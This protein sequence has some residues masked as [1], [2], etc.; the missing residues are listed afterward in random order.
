MY[1]RQIPPCHQ[2]LQRNA[3]AP[4]IVGAT[5][6]KY[7]VPFYQNIYHIVSIKWLFLN[8]LFPL[9]IYSIAEFT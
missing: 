7:R 1:Q 8:I 5:A 3:V 9:R 4:D 6:E 2:L